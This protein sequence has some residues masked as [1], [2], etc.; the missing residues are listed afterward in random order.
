MRSW[1]A[2][3]AAPSS[4]ELLDPPPER[5]HGAEPDLEE[6]LV[7][8]VERLEV[9]GRDEHP[10]RPHEPQRSLHRFPLRPFSAERSGTR[11]AGTRVS[12]LRDDGSSLTTR[13]ASPVG[14]RNTPTT[15]TARVSFSREMVFSALPFG[16]TNSSSTPRNLAEHLLRVPQQRA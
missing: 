11:R 1:P 10:L 14:R 16:S 4:F 7:I 3:S 13:H 2:P 12:V 15:I 5:R 9:L 6:L 8:A